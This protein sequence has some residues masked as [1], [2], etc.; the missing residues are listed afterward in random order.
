MILFQRFT[1][2]IAKSFEQIVG[3]NDRENVAKTEEITLWLMV[4]MA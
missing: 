2:S 3:R 4:G 1:Y